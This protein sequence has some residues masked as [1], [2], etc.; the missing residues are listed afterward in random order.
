MS[1]DN[2]DELARIITRHRM[3]VAA[4]KAAAEQQARSAEHARHDCE[5]P[6]RGIALPLLQE[7]AKRLAVEGY[8]AHVEDR[9]GCR[10]STLVFRLAP[11][12]GPGSALSL[13]CEAGPVV[14][15]S[16]NV[17]G[18]DVGDDA[19]TPLAEL[20][21]RIVLDGLGRF[22]AKALAATIPRRS[23]CGPPVAAAGHAATR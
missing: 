14:R 23:D 4:A 17:D 6:L 22:V 13:V 12:A 7:W 3:D 2:G 1:T 5:G 10:P 18:R 19:E 8:P 21:P 9:L 16:M 15:F 20:E 11:R